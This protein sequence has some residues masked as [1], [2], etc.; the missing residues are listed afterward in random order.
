VGVQAIKVM[1]PR[2]AKTVIIRLIPS[3]ILVISSR[4]LL[5]S[6]SCWR[7]VY[8]ILLQN[9]HKP[10]RIA[11]QNTDV[12]NGGLTLP[13][14]AFQDQKFNFSSRQKFSVND[15]KLNFFRWTA[16]QNTDVVNGG[17]NQ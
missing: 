15:Q 1:K 7:I 3:R 14:K 2:K 5:F 9:Y 10:D 12:V 16:N 13:K 8:F 6:Q 17:F 4:P 11:N